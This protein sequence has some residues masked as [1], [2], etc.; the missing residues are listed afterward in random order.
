M[1]AGASTRG[2]WRESVAE[3]LA[4]VRDGQRV[5]ACGF[6]FTRLPITQLLELRSRR[7][8]T[9]VSWGG[10][11]AL[12]LLLD[13]GAVSTAELTFSSLDFFGLAP[14]FRAAVESGELTLREWTA[15]GM[16]K[17]LE[18]RGQHLGFELMQR[19]T[20]SDI[21]DRWWRPLDDPFGSEGVPQAAVQPLELDVFLLHATRADEAGNV[22]IRGARGLDVSAAF[23]ADRVLVTVEHRV[24][25]G[26]LGAPGAFVLPR[27]FVSGVALAEFGAYPSSCLPDYPADLRQI[28]RIVRRGLEPLS[29]ELLRPSSGAQARLRATARV[30][31]GSLT[32]ALGEIGRARLRGGGADRDE[33]LVCELARTLKPS[34]IAAIGSASV[35]PTAAYL[36]A[37]LLRAPELLMLSFNSGLIDVAWRPLTL[38]FAELLDFRSAAA[39]AGG[40]DTYHWYYQQGRV[41]HE[42][43]ATA[44]LDP[45]AASNTIA[46]KRPN[47]GIVRLPGQGGM[48][49]VANLHVNYLL[50]LPRHDL[51][52]TVPRVDVRGAS[53]V[54]HA[55]EVRRRFGLAPGR[56]AVFSELGTF[57]F[58]TERQ[59]L[60]LTRLRPGVE[61]DEVR[62]R[63]GWPLTVADELSQMA[64]PTEQELATLRERVDPLEIRRLEFASA[65][66]RQALIDE[67]LADEQLVLERALDLDQANRDPTGEHE[68]DQQ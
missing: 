55:P 9:Y 49:D 23:A 61:L 48:A 27:T 17:A 5:G 40:D 37:K 6:N 1:T 11:L 8:L 39:Q 59:T 46:I 64:L 28:A 34:S 7:K 35:L 32:T 38:S 14:R 18:A 62:A 25:V 44:Q 58:D 43:V 42:V 31:S 20:G 4:G 52:N 67:V 2:P 68:P 24:K 13:A 45:T 21:D 33:L 3:L 22:E 53:R 19:V 54:W 30:S 66:R 26:E 56:T 36:L 12:E 47:G 29:E 63:T 41:T 10:G 15:L 51:R 65:N 50:Y 16:I 60:V 57:D